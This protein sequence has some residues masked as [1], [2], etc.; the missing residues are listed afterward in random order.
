LDSNCGSYDKFYITT[1]LRG[2][3]NFN[4]KVSMAK[5]G[6]HSGSYSGIFPDSF[7]VA[8]FVLE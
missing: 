8:R 3:Y 1:S 5:E 6:V 4:L 2:V 7:R